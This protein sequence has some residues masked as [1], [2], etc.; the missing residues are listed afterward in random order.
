MGMLSLGKVKVPRKLGSVSEIDHAAECDPRDAGMR[1]Q[2]VARIWRS[3]QCLY[4][5]GLHPAI[6]LVLRRHGRIVLKRSIGSVSGTAP[7]ERGPVV[8]LHPDSPVCLFSASKAI[9][10]LL[11]HKLV[12]QGKV[13]LGHCVADYVP[14]FAAQGKHSVTVRQLL[15]HRAA[16]PA[17]PMANP[18]LSLLNDWDEVV[19]LLC[20]AKP[21]N[22]HF[23]QQAYHA[24]TAG[25]IIGEIVRRVTGRELPELLREWFAEPLGC[26]HLTFGLAPELRHLA[27]RNVATGLRPFW[28]VT[29][30]ARRAVGVTFDKAIEASNAES[31]L[32]KVV[33]AGNIFATAD[34]T[35][36][37][38]QMLLDGGVYRGRRILRPETV[39]EAIRPVGRIQWDHTLL[40]PM[41]FSA[42]FMLGE[43]PFGLYGPKT[44]TAFGH[45]GFI[46]VLCWADPSRDIS[47]ALLNTGKSIAPAGITRM[48]G[49]LRAIGAACP[50]IA[51][52]QEPASL[53]L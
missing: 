29:A 16:V 39:A 36:R 25:F 34:E 48:I 49:V 43:N 19:R 15:S 41:R 10:S 31:F 11:I 17:I 45:L 13:H 35:S 52:A 50:Q 4:R 2:D 3:V 1:E 28:P 14:E 5:S 23:E 22:T 27:P 30:Y 33:P 7:G 37:V 32:S 8:P 47:V 42:G 40:V 53:L 20:A 44:H 18:D 46:T 21:F 51:P 12:E 9:S 38:F 6:T 24:L 26:E